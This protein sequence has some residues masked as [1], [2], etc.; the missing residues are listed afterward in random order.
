MVEKKLNSCINGIDILSTEE[1][2]VIKSI[3]SLKILSSAVIN[4]GHTK[5]KHIINVHVDKNYDHQNP[6]GFLINFVKKLNLDESCVGLMTAVKMENV[7]IENISSGDF[8]LTLVVT[9]GTSNSIQVG[10]ENKCAPN[11][12]GTINIILITNANL[13]SSAM[14]TTVQVITEAKMTALLNLDI[15][16]Q[17]GGFASGTTTDAIVIGCKGD[18]PE[19]I[20]SGTAT[21]I[22]REI[23]KLVEKAVKKAIIKGDGIKPDRNIKFRLEERGLHIN[24]LINTALEMYV[25]HPGIET[26]EKAKLALTKIFNK[27]LLDPN[28]AILLMAAFR[29]QEDG[30]RGIIPGIQKDKFEKDPVFI[31]ADEIFGMAIS[32]YIAGTKGVFEFYRY[33]REKPGILGKLGVFIDDIIGGLIAGASSLM[34]SEAI[35]FENI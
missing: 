12:S 4:G 35:K 19:I 6:E 11:N 33:D 7:V 3:N 25:P 31:V 30:E 28:V 2:I 34:Y 23:G 14:V 5:A 24:D 27:I 20:Y 15:R 26:K 10:Q 16:S 1:Y 8:Q 9:A 29:M 13:S 18:G 22:G 21:E 32:N 17:Y